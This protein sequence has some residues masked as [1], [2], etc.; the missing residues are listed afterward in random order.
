MRVQIGRFILSKAL[1]PTNMTVLQ[2]AERGRRENNT[3]DVMGI[4]IL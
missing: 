3:K 4:T 2:Y 1:S